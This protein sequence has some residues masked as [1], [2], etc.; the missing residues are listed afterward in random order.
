MVNGGILKFAVYFW[1]LPPRFA[2]IDL[3][4]VWCQTRFRTS[5]ATAEPTRL[6]KIIRFIVVVM[7][8]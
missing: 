8:P 6:S 2:P 5:P 1:F 7:V 4:P 3:L